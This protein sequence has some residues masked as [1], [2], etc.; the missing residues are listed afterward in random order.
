VSTLRGFVAAAAATTMSLCAAAQAGTDGPDN[1]SLLLFAGTDVWRDGAFLHGGLLWSP[2][3]LD[4]DGF[5][6]IR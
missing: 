4:V 1:R 3:G 5:T 2:A 6:G